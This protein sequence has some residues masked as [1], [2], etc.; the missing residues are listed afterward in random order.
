[1][2]DCDANLLKQTYSLS[3]NAE[4][5]VRSG[6]ISTEELSQL[7][8]NRLEIPVEH[9]PGRYWYLTYTDQHKWYDL[10][11]TTIRG[12]DKVLAIAE[13]NDSDKLA[14][15]ERAAES[16]EIL[17]LQTHTPIQGIRRVLIP[18]QTSAF[19]Y[20][21][22]QIHPNELK[23]AVERIGHDTIPIADRSSRYGNATVL[24]VYSYT[25]ANRG[26]KLSFQVEGK[27]ALR[28]MSAQDFSRSGSSDSSA[29]GN[30]PPLV[31]Q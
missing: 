18:P 31:P 15:F 26:L 24:S 30:S 10:Y 9:P 12:E 7:I 8:K 28:L 13:A 21:R 23:E 29:S 22:Y 1:M 27:K 2:A 17:V 16:I 4:A 20:S 3:S 25:K 6:K 19:L 5:Y 11:M 14:Y